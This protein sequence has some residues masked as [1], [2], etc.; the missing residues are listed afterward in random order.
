MEGATGNNGGKGEH[1]KQGDSVRKLTAL[2]MDDPICQRVERALLM[3]L[4]VEA[5]GVD[6]AHD[7]F[8]L[9]SEGRSF[10]LII[11]CSILPGINGFMATRMLRAMGV[12]CKILGLCGLTVEQGRQAFLDA[13]AD[14][15]Y[16]KPIKAAQLIPILKE[17]DPN[18]QPPNSRA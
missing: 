16:E 15:Y 13:G 7:A 8:K 1:S 17:I 10:D 12:Q 14:G 2:V 11:L 3:S 9:L 18:Y 6:N 5:H 4:D